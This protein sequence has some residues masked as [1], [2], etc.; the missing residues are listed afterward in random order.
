MLLRLF[1]CYGYCHHLKVRLF[2]YLFVSIQENASLNAAGVIE[3]A[4]IVLQELGE[5]EFAQVKNS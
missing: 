1:F 4:I 2:L 5:D 3:I